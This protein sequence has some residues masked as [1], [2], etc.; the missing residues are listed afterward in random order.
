[1]GMSSATVPM[2]TVIQG[3]IRFS[4][5]HFTVLYQIDSTSA[6]PGQVDTNPGSLFFESN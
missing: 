6:V 2:I 4:W 3:T 5:L 1:M